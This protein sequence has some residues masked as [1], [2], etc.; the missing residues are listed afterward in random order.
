MAEHLHHPAGLSVWLSHGFA[1]RRILSLSVRV[2]CLKQLAG[3]EVVSCS[4][5]CYT[6]L[7]DTKTLHIDGKRSYTVVA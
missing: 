1:V 3:A 2:Y 6:V 7:L 4:D 5:L